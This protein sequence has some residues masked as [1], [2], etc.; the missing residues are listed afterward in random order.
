MTPVLSPSSASQFVSGFYCFSNGSSCFF[1]IV[2][3]GGRYQE[4]NYD[5]LDGPQPVWSANQDRPVEV[6]ATLKLTG[7]GDLILED[8][9]GD[10]VWSTNTGGKSVMGLRFTEFGNLVLFDSNNAT[11][12][13][14]FDHP[15][16]SLLIG[17]TQFMRLEP[18]GYLKV[19]EWVQSEWKTMADLLTSR[20]GDCGYPTVCGKYGIRSSNGQCGCFAGRSNEVKQISYKQTN[21]GCSLVT[22]ISCDHSQYH[23]LVELKNISY[24][25]LN[26]RHLYNE[27]DE[28]TGLEDCK[29]AC[30][31]NCSCKAALFVGTSYYYP[32]TRGCMLLSEVFSLIDD[33]GRS[34]NTSIFLKVPNAPSK[35]HHPLPPID[36]PRKKSTSGRIILGSS[37]GAVFGVCLFGWILHFRF[38]NEKRTSGT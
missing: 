29:N 9:D 22:P 1:G 20:F 15:T 12:W 7:Y 10:M 5:E 34:D 13:Q 2:I 18:D 25:T 21:L 36:F 37:L 28:K 38:Q 30:L 33:E 8:A 31:R 27:L 6:N 32:A 26:W 17:Q 16:D 14:S 3:C 4:Q 24:F 35:H 11:V 19:Y 23:S